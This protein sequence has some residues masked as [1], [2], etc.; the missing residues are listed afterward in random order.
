MGTS[1]PFR[2]AR[3]SCAPNPQAFFHSRALLQELSGGWP[4][5]H[6]AHTQ[7]F[8]R[9]HPR[10]SAHF[11][12]SKLLH[13]LNPQ[14]LF[15][16]FGYL[17]GTT[18][19]RSL[20]SLTVLQPTHQSPVTLCQNASN[21]VLPSPSQQPLQQ[22][23]TPSIIPLVWDNQHV[24]P[25]TPFPQPGSALT[26]HRQD[27]MH[28]AWP[29]AIPQ[30][31]TRP[32]RLCLALCHDCVGLITC[33]SKSRTSACLCQAPAPE[34]A[35]SHHTTG[36][37]CC[38]LRLLPCTQRQAMCWITRSDSSPPSSSSPVSADSCSSSDSPS[39]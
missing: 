32:L 4:P 17:P 18:E 2:A 27:S 22:D 30:V 14:G 7:G 23:P 36:Q 19:P 5:V 9:L 16:S 6:S 37:L 38:L 31:A 39:I 12:I 1:S 29:T 28:Q 15:P 21:P 10:A 33:S 24:G 35:D 3:R 13:S 26:L 34:Q 8:L 25:H 11:P 20:L